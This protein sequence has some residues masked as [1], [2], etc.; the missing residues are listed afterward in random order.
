M[1]LRINTNVPALTAHR[2]LS[3]SMQQMTSV[4]ARLSSGLRINTASDDPAGLIISEGMRAQLKGLNQAIRNSQDAINMTKTAEA[5]L[6]EVQRL[7]NNMR[8]LAVHSANTA[9][10]DA[11]QL[12]ANQT[13]IQSAIQSIDRIGSQTQWGTKKL[14]DGTAGTNA[15]IT[16]SNYVTSIYVGST[17]N[18]KSIANGPVTLQRVT[19]AEQAVITT[20]NNFASMNTVVT[21]IGTF[22][23]NG[24]AFH[25]NGTMTVGQLIT[26]INEAAPTTGVV[27]SLV[28]TNIQ[29]RT[30]DYG[31]SKRV[32]FFD[33]SSVL[34][35]APFTSDE[36][37][38]AVFN[39]SMTTVEGVQ[40]VPMTGGRMAGDSGLRL[41]DSWGNSI[42]LTPAG[43]QAFNPAAQA[44]YVTAGAVQ[45][46]VGANAGQNISYSMP[47]IF[48]NRLGTGA[49]P[50][51]S[52]AT[53]DLTSPQGAQDAI[54]IIDAAI[55][56][57]ALLRGRLGSF[58]ANYLE[59]NVRSLNIATENM[60]SAES[61]IRDADMAIEMT[62]YVR[63]QILQQ[64]GM[65]MLAQANQAPQNILQL[66]RGA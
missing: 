9:V 48:A 4:M 1:S 13:Q 24:Y 63:L 50:G 66:L 3:N 47:T 19:A 42:M 32:D 5:A 6:D 56:E 7:L 10:V 28:G 54:R 30:I 58:Q 44:A 23:I 65:A 55:M 36:G 12:Q 2:N 17:F 15:N 57:L 34:H 60:A 52:V 53:I 20:A 37:V 49:V 45:F 38:D 26:K 27:A 33:P 59:S 40:T 8:A 62:E 11:A 39:V 41:T 25:S 18:G 64:S 61:Q 22:V 21:Q 14:L 43:N 29:L 31:A 51:Q 16:N 35:N 46:Q